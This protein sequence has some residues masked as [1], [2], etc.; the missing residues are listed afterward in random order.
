MG[1][2]EQIG[3]HMLPVQICFQIC[4]VLTLKP[5][6]QGHPF[7]E[8]ASLTGPQT[9]RKVLEVPKMAQKMRICIRYARFGLRNFNRYDLGCGV[10]PQKTPK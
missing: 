9:K 3:N 5:I 8:T 10:L 1:T 7:S 4:P 2:G 6:F